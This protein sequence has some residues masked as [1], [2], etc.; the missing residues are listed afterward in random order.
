MLPR[1][2][3]IFL[4][5]YRL[6]RSLIVGTVLTLA[7]YVPFTG[8]EALSVG[9]LAALVVDAVLFCR[10]WSLDFENQGIV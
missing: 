7:F 9:M 2:R 1:Q 6:R 3:Y 5:R 10:A 4:D 8:T